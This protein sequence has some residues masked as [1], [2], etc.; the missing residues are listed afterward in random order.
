MKEWSEKY[1]QNF[2]DSNQGYQTS[3]VLKF[4]SKRIIANDQ[5]NGGFY[6]N[7]QRIKTLP[8]ACNTNL[9]NLKINEIAIC[10]YLNR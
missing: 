10:S 8:T 1:Y 5:I 3:P 9:V 4:S 7:I 2:K 6:T